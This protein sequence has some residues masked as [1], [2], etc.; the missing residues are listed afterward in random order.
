MLLLFCFFCLC[1][2]YEG[3]IWIRA[4]HIKTTMVLGVANN[5]SLH[6]K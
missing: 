1:D 6:N 4:E 2:F 3:V 5:S